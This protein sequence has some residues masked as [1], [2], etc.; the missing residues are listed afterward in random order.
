[1]RLLPDPHCS[2]ATMG[3]PFSI[4]CG[5]HI[6]RVNPLQSPKKKKKK[7]QSRLQFQDAVQVLLK[8]HNETG[9]E[10]C[11]HR[12][13]PVEPRYTHLLSREVWQKVV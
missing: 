10:D 4:L 2:T 11:R 7:F 8:K 13:K 3:R 12:Q 9:N 1:M 6:L 5:L